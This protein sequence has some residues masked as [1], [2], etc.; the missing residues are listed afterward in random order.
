MVQDNFKNIR[1]VEEIYPAIIRGQD[2]KPSRRGCQV[3]RVNFHLF[4]GLRGAVVSNI[5]DNYFK[6]ESFFFGL[7][8]IFFGELRAVRGQMK[9]QRDGF[10]LSFNRS[11]TRST[12]TVLPNARLG[13]MSHDNVFGFHTK[14]LQRFSMK[15]A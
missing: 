5:F 2:S 15:Q 10:N 9:N 3:T 7:G 11:R 13:Y 4:D 12:S 1:V 6:V 14:K 8:E